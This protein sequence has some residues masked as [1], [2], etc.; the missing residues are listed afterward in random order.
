MFYDSILVGNYANFEDETKQKLRI[1]EYQKALLEKVSNLYTIDCEEIATPDFMILQYAFLNGHCGLTKL[2]DGK[3]HAGIGQYTGTNLNP[4]GLLD[5]YTITFANGETYT[6]KVGKDVVVLWW[7]N[8]AGSQSEMLGRYAYMLAD[9]DCSM[10]YNIKYSRVCPIP[11]VENDIEENSMKEVINNL[12]NGVTKIF[13]RSNVTDL[14]GANANKQNNT[15]DLTQPQTAVYLQNLSRFHDEWI[16]RA[17]LEFGVYVSARDKGAQLND[18]ELDAFADYCAI[19]ADD[20]YN[21]LKDF[22]TECERVFG[23]S[24]SVAPKA[25]VYTEKDVANEEEFENVSRETLPEN[26]EEASNEN[27]NSND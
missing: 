13:K 10:V 22:A 14:L 11:I 26:E 24:V 15:L 2:S 17:C 16:I 21:R 4:E 18:K 5:E 1:A 12:F 23:I 3:Y 6:G 9:T 27:G 25:F 7:N 8:L 19:S 20:T